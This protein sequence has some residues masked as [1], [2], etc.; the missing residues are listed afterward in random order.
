MSYPFPLNA[1]ETAFPRSRS[2]FFTSSLLCP[3]TNDLLINRLEEQNVVTRCELSTI[4]T[5]EIRDLGF[6][7]TED[8][9]KAIINSEWLQSAFSSV[10]PSASSLSILF[11]PSYRPVSTLSMGLARGVADETIDTTIN[12]DDD[13]WMNDN[14]HSRRKEREKSKAKKKESKRNKP[15]QMLRLSADGDFG[16]SVVSFSFYLFRSERETQGEMLFNK[17]HST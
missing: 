10:D 3:R 2:R 1:E 6:S 5:Y 11:S 7:S 12:E 9:A 16:S 14:S 15:V 8:V 4:D 13:G 17:D